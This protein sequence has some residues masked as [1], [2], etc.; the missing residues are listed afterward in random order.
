MRKT[1]S[2]ISREK[3]GRQW[4]VIEKVGNGEVKCVWSFVWAEK[5]NI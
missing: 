4:A 2:D 3:I 5:F 1:L